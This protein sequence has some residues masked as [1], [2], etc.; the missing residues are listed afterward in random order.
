MESLSLE[1]LRRCVDVALGDVAGHRGDG[2]VAGFG[3][4]RGLF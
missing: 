2:L 3:D 1:V 4:I